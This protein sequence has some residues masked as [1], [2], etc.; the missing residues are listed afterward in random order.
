[1]AG[2]STGIVWSKLAS[3]PGACRA[4]LLAIVLLFSFVASAQV[5]AV[6]ECDINALQI[7]ALH[8]LQDEVHIVTSPLR[9]QPN[10][11]LWIAPFAAY[12]AVGFVAGSINHDEHLRET[13]ML[14]TE[15]GVDALILN[16]GLQYALDRQDPKQGSQT[17]KFWPHG[18]KTWSDG[19]SIPSEH[20]VN[21]W[22]FARVVAS[23]YPGWRTQ[24]I[25]YSM[26]TTVSFRECSLDSISPQM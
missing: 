24:L 13:S 3:S 1:M 17:G 9:I 25:V 12:S 6:K 2:G 5:A 15:A 4:G 23:E 22:S 20:C 8:V 16:T 14:V 26:A 11:L 7:C 21:V 10:D 18:T 19:T